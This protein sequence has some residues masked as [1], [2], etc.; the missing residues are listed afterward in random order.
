[1]SH[2]LIIFGEKYSLCLT[3]AEYIT[4]VS[5]MVCMTLCDFVT[6]VLFGIALACKICILVWN[7]SSDYLPD[8]PQVSSSLCKIHAIAAY[9]QCIP[10]IR[11]FRLSGDRV[12]TEHTSKRWAGRR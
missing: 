6:G 12:Y 9:A 7:G 10:A 2:L 3:R 8:L 5:I 1:M 11:Q 4:I